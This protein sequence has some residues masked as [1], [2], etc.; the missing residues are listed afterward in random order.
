MQECFGTLLNPKKSLVNDF[1][2]KFN[3][4]C[5]IADS[6]P[7]G[8][9]F[10]K[11]VPVKHPQKLFI[12]AVMICSLKESMQ[13][14]TAFGSFKIRRLKRGLKASIPYVQENSNPIHDFLHF[15]AFTTASVQLKKSSGGPK[16]L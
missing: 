7:G 8:T 15:A 1:E 10:E 16:G 14:M 2:H 6:L 4:S 9:L 11:T 12:K 13:T 3:L 5:E